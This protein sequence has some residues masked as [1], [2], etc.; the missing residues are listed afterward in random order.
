MKVT[1]TYP[2]Y[3]FHS[4]EFE[5]TCPA[6]VAADTV[7]YALRIITRGKRTVSEKQHYIDVIGWALTST[8]PEPPSPPPVMIHLPAYH[9][10]HHPCVF[11]RVVTAEMYLVHHHRLHLHLTTWTRDFTRTS[12]SLP[13]PPPPATNLIHHRLFQKLLNSLHRYHLHHQ[14]IHVLFPPTPPA[15]PPPAT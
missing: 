3:T 11:E 14:G 2:K 6:V 12:N 15:P 9:H 1:L 4:D 5:Y 10:R 8:I 13:P 7:E